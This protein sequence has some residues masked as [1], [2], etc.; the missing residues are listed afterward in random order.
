MDGE[1][2]MADKASITITQKEDYQFLVDFGEA[3][4]TLLVDQ[5]LPL[6]KDEG[7]SPEY[8]LL[9]ASANCLLASLLFALRKFKADAGRITATASC[10]LERNVNNRLRVGRI[11]VDIRLEKE[12]TEIAHI[13]R[14]LMQFEDFCTV[15]QSVQS[16]IPIT[17]NVHDGKGIRLDW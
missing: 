14:A 8:M 16:G 7:P 9:A 4:P 10:E 6:G 17:V 13:E 2:I 3:M 12:K 1:R 11:D 15:S 5:P